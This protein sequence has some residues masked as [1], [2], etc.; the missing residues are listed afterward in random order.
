MLCG[1][2]MSKKYY[3]KQ[4][5]HESH[6]RKAL[7]EYLHLQYPNTFWLF[8][9]TG[10]KMPIGQ[11]K[12]L[13]K[14]KCRKGIPD[15]FMAEKTSKYNGLFIELKR[16]DRYVEKIIDDENFGSGKLKEHI[17]EQRKMIEGLNDRGYYATFA[18]GFEDAKAV[19]DRYLSCVVV[20]ETSR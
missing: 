3:K 5:N 15:F 17:E 1:K 18:V 8:D 19:I 20:N 6:I 10:E 4:A 14:L 7:A 12:K 16:D 13:S 9:L 2:K 11:A